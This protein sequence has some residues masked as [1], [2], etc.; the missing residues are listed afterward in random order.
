MEDT[1]I[2]TTTWNQHTRTESENDNLIWNSKREISNRPETET[3][4]SRPKMI[5]SHVPEGT[6]KA[7]RKDTKEDME[8]RETSVLVCLSVAL[9]N[10]TTKATQAMEGFV[11]TS[12]VTVHHW[13]QS[14]QEPKRKRWRNFTHQ[15]RISFFLYRPDRLPTWV[16]HCLKEAGPFLIHLHSQQPPKDMATG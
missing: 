3:R 6:H 12:Y 9:I 14:E 15:L 11:L 7:C 10:P 5:G 16:W 8:V 2:Q 13:G 1:L 4:K